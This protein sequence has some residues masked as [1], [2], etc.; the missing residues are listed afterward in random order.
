M[1]IISTPRCYQTISTLSIPTSPFI[2]FSTLLQYAPYI[3][4]FSPHFC[5]FLH[6][7]I[8][9]STL[10]FLLTCNLLHTFTIFS[11]LLLFA[12]YFSPFFYQFFSTFVIFPTFLQIAIYSCNLLHTYN[13][14]RNFIIASKLGTCILHFAILYA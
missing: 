12:P 8:I 3:Y 5:N 10:N 7:F 2:L 14:L 11:T 9:F 1:Y 4:I 6:T 13:L